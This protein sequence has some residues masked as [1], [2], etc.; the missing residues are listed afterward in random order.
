[1]S[2]PSP[3][4]YSDQRTIYDVIYANDNPPQFYGDSH[5][6]QTGACSHLAK[7]KQ[8]YKQV[9]DDENHV[10]ENYRTLV[11][12]SMSWHKSRKQRMTEQVGKKRKYTKEVHNHDIMLKI[13]PSYSFFFLV[14]ASSSV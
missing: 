5:L 12:Y 3:F 13:I 2:P 1:M 11:R 8:K 9:G 6:I 14:V 7:L 4:Q 10:F